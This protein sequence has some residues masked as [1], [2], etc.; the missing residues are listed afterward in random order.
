AGWRVSL[1]EPVAEPGSG[2]I[3]RG[4][5]LVGLVD[6]SDQIRAS[7]LMRGFLAHFRAGGR[8]LRP[9]VRRRIASL[10]TAIGEVDSHAGNSGSRRVGAGDR[11]VE[12]GGA[13]EDDGQAPR[14][15]VQCV[16]RVP[17]G[18]WPG[19]PDRG[20]LPRF[21]R[22]AVRVKARGSARADQC[23]TGSART[24]AVA[25]A[26]GDLGWGFS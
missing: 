22:R 23:P 24:P 21:H 4:S 13:V 20:G 9:W 8:V 14:G 11:R 5:V 18:S 15:G 6:G 25:P 16:R 7:S 12:G 1:A 2:H 3:I 10:F 19:G 26:D 17:R